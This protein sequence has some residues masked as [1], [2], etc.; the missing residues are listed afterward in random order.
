MKRQ[1]EELYSV[2]KNITNVKDALSM[3]SKAQ[4]DTHGEAQKLIEFPQGTEQLGV[5]ATRIDVNSSAYWNHYNHWHAQQSNK[6]A[7]YVRN[8]SC[9][10]TT[11][12]TTTTS[13]LGNGSCEAKH[14]KWHNR[15]KN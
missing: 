8:S 14:K 9:N 6:V 2:S 1:S 10:N 3:S 12:E 11:W 7:T 5:T 15:K 4:E 13:R